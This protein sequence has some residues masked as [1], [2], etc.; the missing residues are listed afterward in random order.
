M[1]VGG[2]EAQLAGA[3]ADLDAG[4]RVDLL[5]LGGDLL[6]AIGGAVVDDDELPVEV[7]RQAASAWAAARTGAGLLVGEGL[8]EQPGDDGQIAALVV[9]GQE[10]RVLV[11]GLLGRHC[12][13]GAC[14]DVAVGESA[15]SST[16]STP[17]ELGP[18]APFGRPLNPARAPLPTIPLHRPCP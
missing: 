17:G 6:G 5:Q 18:L 14:V 13:L 16:V 15:E 2:A 11:L 3:G 8:V 12:V 1:D 4:G 9:G 10:H 7:A